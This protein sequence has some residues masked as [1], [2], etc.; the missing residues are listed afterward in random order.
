MGARL[1]AAVSD[2]LLD[3]GCARYVL[4][5][6]KYI[7]LVSLQLLNA[8]GSHLDLGRAPYVLYGAKHIDLVPRERFAGGS[9][10]TA[11]RGSHWGL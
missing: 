10:G 2:S 6:A 11:W 9:C 7:G 8:S 5:G 1:P 4:Y 3:L